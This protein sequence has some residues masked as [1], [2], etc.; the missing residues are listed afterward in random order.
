MSAAGRSAW[1]S[2]GTAA[3][4]CASRGMGLYRVD[5]SGA[6]EELTTA[7][8]R[9]PFSIVDDSR[10]LFTDDV[11]IGPD[12]KV[13]FSE[14]TTRYGFDEWATDAI[15]GRG[16]GRIIR[17]DP[18]SGVTRTVVRNLLFAN[19]VCMAHDN[20]SVLF[21][22]TWGCRVSRYWLEGPR[23]GTTEVVIADLPGYPDNI[24]RG[25][26][27][28][29]WVAISATRTPSFD[30]AMTMPAFR[31]RM[32][33]RVAGDEWLFPNVNF[34]GVARF[35]AEGR[36][37]EI[38][39]GPSPRKPSDHQFDAGAS[40]V[41]LPQRCRQQPHRADQASRCRSGMDL[42]QV[43]LGRVL[44]TPFSKTMDRW[45]GRGEASITT[46]PMDGAFRPND[47]LDSAASVFE[48]PAPDDLAVTSHGV[49]VSSQQSLFR[50]D[51][52]GGSSI[53][54][55]AAPISAIAGLP[56]GGAA[57]ALID[58]QIVFLGGQHEGKTIKARA[59]VT[60]ITA[61]AAAR[62]GTLF[63]ANGSA[64]NGPADWKRDLMEKNATG[65]VWRLEPG[66]GTYTRLVA[67][68]AYP[69]GLVEEDNSLVVAESWRS[70]LTRI[71]PQRKRRQYAGAGRPCR[72]SRP[73]VARRRRWNLARPVCAAQPNSSSS[74]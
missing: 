56:D 66:T 73:T 8:N 25:S 51:K 67:G 13:Y 27:G 72:L 5:T 68:L 62:D 55:F 52:P 3:W 32:A 15:E 21:A 64:T 65:S 59:G 58:G 33:R 74:Y 35:D 7:T 22:E 44:M 48:T 41:S 57:A 4:W 19:G 20:K 26:R 16:N 39:L 29:Y 47:L 2:T 9:S 49:V 61:L 1:P 24:N 38:A 63:V 10:M 12:G 50:V 54:S 46:P 60:C 37:L 14:A 11:D 28:T 31:R 53:A 36:V 42:P 71:A 40:G 18:A 17:Y 6:V 70:A 23:A 69:H 30:L 43:L 34:G 45:L